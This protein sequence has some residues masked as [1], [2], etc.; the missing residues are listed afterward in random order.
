MRCGDGSAVM[1]SRE[2]RRTEFVYILGSVVCVRGEYKYT[3][4]LES[5]KNPK[6][7]VKESRIRCTCVMLHIIINARND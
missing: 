5:L 7:A 4:C 1:R 6:F 2:I 3:E